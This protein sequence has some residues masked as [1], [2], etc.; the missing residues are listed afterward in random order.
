M[1][2]LLNRFQSR[3]DNRY[4][5]DSTIILCEDTRVTAKLLY[6]YKILGQPDITTPSTDQ[7]ATWWAME[8]G[9]KRSQRQLV[10]L[11]EHNEAARISEVL[12]VWRW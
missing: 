6:H 1:C 12:Q 11:H 7:H 9:G 2:L 10:S 4:F 8:E 3:Y 5:T